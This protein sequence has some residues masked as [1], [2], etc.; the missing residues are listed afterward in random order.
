VALLGRHTVLCKTMQANR[1]HLLPSCDIHSWD[2][3]FCHGNEVSKK[4]DIAD[5]ACI[6]WNVSEQIYQDQNVRCY[7]KKFN[8]LYHS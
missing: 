2:S 6:K 4:N 1:S 5:Y 8:C 7:L 3:R